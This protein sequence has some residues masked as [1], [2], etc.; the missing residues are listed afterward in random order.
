MGESCLPFSSVSLELVLVTLEWKLLRAEKRLE[1]DDERDEP[2]RLVGEV[3]RPVVAGGRRPPRQAWVLPFLTIALLGVCCGPR[4]R[5]AIFSP[6][7]LL[8]LLLSLLL[9][10]LVWW[11]GSWRTVA[12]L[13]LQPRP[14]PLPVPIRRG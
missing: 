13:R 4:T 11:R 6:S 3:D 8:L 12:R 10:L 7:L 14:R 1:A 5:R 2:R 9:L